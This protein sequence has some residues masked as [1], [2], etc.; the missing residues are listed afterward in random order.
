M[1]RLLPIP[2]DVMDVLEGIFGDANERVARKMS[3]MPSVHETSLDLTLI[4]H[5]SNFSAPVTLGSGWTLR[6]DTHFLGGR[7]HFRSWEIADVG[8]LVMFRRGGR[9][10]RSKVGLLQAKRLYPTEQDFEEDEPFD[11]MV[12][13]GQLLEKTESFLEVTEPRSFSFKRSSRYKALAIGDE[14]YRAIED[15][16]ARYEIPVHYML[17]HPLR[18]PSTTSVPRTSYRSPPGPCSAGCRVVPAVALRTALASRDHGYVP[19]YGD[20]EFSLTSPFDQPDHTCGWR[21]EHFVA[22]LLVTC[23]QGYIAETRSDEGLFQVF[24]RRSGPIS[25][26]IGVTFDAPD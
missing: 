16:E 21:L 25:A 22:Q 17:Y 24:N 13:F 1:S 20:L 14:Q 3:G 7:R 19:S 26:A 8:V 18:V 5:L 6:L 4:E 12:G 11:Y 10:V 15:Y 2:Q 9:L 23:E